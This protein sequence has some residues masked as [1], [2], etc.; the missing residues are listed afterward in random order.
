M[1]WANFGSGEPSVRAAWTWDK[2]VPNNARV[3]IGGVVSATLWPE[4]RGGY[5]LKKV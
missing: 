2:G 4:I 3:D 5:G 1:S